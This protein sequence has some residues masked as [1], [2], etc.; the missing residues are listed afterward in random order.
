MK[1]IYITMDSYHIYKKHINVRTME[2]GKSG[3]INTYGSKWR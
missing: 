3:R 1:D 2:G